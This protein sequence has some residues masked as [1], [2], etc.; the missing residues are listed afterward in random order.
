MFRKPNPPKK[1]NLSQFGLIDIPD[2]DD[3]DEPLDMSDDDMDFEAE[4]AAI[5]GG[6]AKS[7]RPRKPAP[8]PSTNLDAMIA[9]SLKD[10]PSDED[11]SDEDDPDLLNE[12]Q[13][14]SLEDEAPSAPPRT[15]RPAPPPPGVPSTLSTESSTVSLLQER[16]SNYTIAEKNAKDSGESGRARSTGKPAEPKSTPESPPPRV[17]PRTTSFDVVVD[18]YKSGTDMD[19][20]ELP[21]PEVIAAA[22]RSQRTDETTQQSTA[23]RMGRIVK[24]FQEAVKLNSAGKPIAGDDLPTPPGFAPL[25]TDG[26]SRRMGRIVKQFQEAVKLNSAGKPIAGDDLPTP[27]G[28]A[29]LPTDG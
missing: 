19:L 13:G 2:L 8:V 7:H 26:V 25:P 11:V 12:L 24:Q 21:T 10:I 6:S 27:P 28:F 15:S 17:P 20:N 3:G 9:E 1:G 18:A 14:L 5:S 29:P 4:L 16:I 23:R 22:L